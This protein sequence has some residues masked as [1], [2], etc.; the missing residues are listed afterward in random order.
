MATKIDYNQSVM[1][2]KVL[3][4]LKT[5]M[6]T[7]VVKLQ[8]IADRYETKEIRNAADEYISAVKMQ[9][10]F[11]TYSK[12]SEYAL[13]KMGIYDPIYLNDPSTIPREYR[14]QLVLYQR[15]YVLAMY[16]EQNNYYRTLNGLP[17]YGTTDFIYVT[18][19]ETNPIEGV[20][21]TKPIHLMSVD[22][23]NIISVTGYLDRL[24]VLHPDKKYLDFIDTDKKIDI[25]SAREA[26]DYSILY[27]YSDRTKQP[28]TEM[29][30]ALYNNNRTYV[31]D[32]FYDKVYEYNSEYYRGY[33]GLFM[34]SIT[35]QR[36]ITNYFHK[37][38]NRDFYDK[39][40]IRLLF[41]S[42]GL[43]FY[44]EIPLSYLQ[45]VAKNLNRLLRYRSQDR[46]FTDIFKIFDMD[47]I[48]VCN[49]ILFK[50]PVM[51]ENDKPVQVYKEKTELGY[52]INTDS[53]LL[54]STDTFYGASKLNYENVKKIEELYDGTNYCRFILM[55]NGILQIAEDDTVYRS[56]YYLVIN[57]VKSSINDY[58]YLQLDEYYN[59]TNM[60]KIKE[61]DGT[62]SI[63]LICKSP[64]LIYKITK[65]N[66]QVIDIRTKLALTKTVFS[67]DVKQDDINGAIAYIVNYQTTSQVFIYSN[68]D[69]LI[70]RSQE[71]DDTIINS[72]FN[73]NAIV[74][75]MASGKFYI[76]GNN[77][78]SR[79][80]YR[81]SLFLNEFTEVN[82]Q[83][84]KVVDVKIMNRGMI[85]IINN[86]TVRY[87]R[88]VPE[89][90][91][92]IADFNNTVLTDYSGIKGIFKLND[93]TRT[94][95]CFISYQGD[96]YFVNYLYSDKFGEL[97][98]QSDI[99]K[100]ACYYKFIKNVSCLHDGFIITTYGNT[101]TI[102]YSGKNTDANFPYITTM[103][104]INEEN[105]MNIEFV[106][107]YNGFMFFTTIDNKFMVY[108]GNTKTDLTSKIEQCEI[109]ALINT[110]DALFILIGKSYLYMITGTTNEDMTM[111]KI[112]NPNNEVIVD[113]FREG[114][115]Y[116]DLVLKT[117]TNKLY[118]YNITNN[119]FTL[120][121]S[122]DMYHKMDNT[123]VLIKNV[124][125]SYKMNITIDTTTYTNVVI[126]DVSNLIRVT[127]CGSVL[128][129][130]GDK[131]YYIKLSE[132]YTGI[133]SIEAYVHE[134][135]TTKRA[136]SI[137]IN[138]NL[139]IYNKAG[140]ISILRNFIHAD[141]L[142]CQISADYVS[143]LDD[144]S[145]KV[146]DIVFDAENIIKL[147]NTSQYVIYE[148][149]VKDMYKLSFVEIPMDAPNK[150]EYL[151]DTSY[152]LDYDLVVS[153]DKLWGG[154]RDRD[155]FLNEVLKSEYNYLTSKYIS[156]NST[157]DLTKLNFEVCYMF[158]LLSELKDSERYLNLEIKFIGET[159]LFEAVVALFALTCKKFGL[160]GNILN[161][162]TMKLSV[163]GFN[164]S[165]DN[166]YI[167]Q[168]VKDAKL[169]KRD[170]S[171]RIE[172]IEIIRNP[173]LFANGTEIVNLYLDNENILQNIYNYKYNA[174]TIQEYNAYKRIEQASL[175]SQYYNE[176]YKVDGVVSDTYLDYLRRVNPKL[177][178][179]V[180]ETTDESILEVMDYI[181]L[182]LT[183]F[184]D[185]DK[186]KYLFFNIPT[187]SL[188]LIKR[189]IYY[190]VNIFK[191]YTVDLKSM[192]VIYHVDDKRLHNIKLILSEDNFEKEW[193]WEDK[194]RI[195][196]F[197]TYLL[198]NFSDFDKI[199]IIFEE[200]FDSQLEYKEAL[201]L[202]RVFQTIPQVMEQ[203]I[204]SLFDDFSDFFDSMD[205][206]WES[207]NGRGFERQRLDC[208]LKAFVEVILE[209]ETR[210]KLSK[211]IFLTD[212]FY[213]D[214]KMIE[215]ELIN[216]INTME[217]SKDII[218]KYAELMEQLGLFYNMDI[219][220]FKDAL[221]DIVIIND[222]L[223]EIPGDFMDTISLISTMVR[224]D[225]INNIRDDYYFIRNE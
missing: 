163:L 222:R 47:N 144:P 93:G 9:D 23:I 184:M 77:R 79:L 142:D 85:L 213:T 186:F 11:Y 220:K 46:V 132:L 175:Y 183:E 3:K 50:N 100:P 171:F 59:F 82:D 187:I 86:G 199:K 119:T 91:S 173:R 35:G 33:M 28:I 63:Y 109:Q 172:D 57:D 214:D 60:K 188:D 121:T 19:V 108:K 92:D 180:N 89:L 90:G 143:I 14:D 146:T 205:G 24:K 129:L 219:A 15:E 22:E 168:V 189:F 25:I 53:Y 151:A 88:T 179:M 43:P 27:I 159:P 155:E 115:S 203:K 84:F 78:D 21:V 97:L 191:S 49:Y 58:G 103:N 136:K 198:N 118:K 70:K 66:L 44:N 127:I 20:D 216:F 164:F 141:R 31:L 29:F 149:V 39:D 68:T 83:A 2:D 178:K 206:Y 1:M 12:Y 167:E 133:T 212:D 117:N 72:D 107:I 32:R 124:S 225:N 201:W 54:E 41:Q 204:E 125:G 106:Q 64:Y 105:E 135:L 51:D 7:I 208:L 192:N 62:D 140:G 56:M 196:D 94:I 8:F 113:V 152:H 42:Y 170:P 209:K 123:E 162:T 169:Y 111:K 55:N 16:E 166:T 223:D 80:L 156:I 110:G 17:D 210:I 174:K 6:T 61:A 185:S 34:L 130:E 38:I 114:Q 190:L 26:A 10:N 145:T 176:I 120:V 116:N 36:F 81:D 52:N 177:Y 161:T 30:I 138:D 224:R 104:M 193:I 69:S 197:I 202:L 165:L 137:R 4:E 134:A 153:D 37:F 160:E 74:N 154:N 112:T 157:Y 221:N 99:P 195:I 67:L 194:A 181:L 207:R 98:Y 40:I 126:N 122:Y 75:V 76:Y 148:P 18:E 218:I 95:Y 73:D 215:R 131:I 158:K 128:F 150:A 87:S 147:Q 211:K 200:K 45:K 217:F 101:S 13:N 65:N 102:G 5:M 182:A 48:E 96:L 71:F 139:I